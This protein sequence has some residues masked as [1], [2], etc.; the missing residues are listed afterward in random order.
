[1]TP[2]AI[3]GAN[4]VA[5]I[6]PVGRNTKRDPKRRDPRQRKRQTPAD[7]EDLM[8]HE[9]EPDGEEDLVVLDDDQDDA[10]GPAFDVKV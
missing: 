6:P 4:E 5:G 3:H 9:H 2:D 7:V 8:D 1:M 10:P